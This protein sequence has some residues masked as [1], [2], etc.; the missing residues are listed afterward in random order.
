MK[1][2]II[3]CFIGLTSEIAFG[4]TV[5]ETIKSTDN[6]IIG[7]ARYMG[8]AG[9]F[10]A[11]GGDVSA[12]KDNPAGLGIFR[13]SELTATV[14]ALMQATTA[15]WNTKKTDDS[16]YS[17]GANNVSLVLASKTWRAES[18]YA[19]LI[20]SNFSF[21]YNKLQNFN[22]NM[23]IQSNTVGSSMTDYF[24]HFTGKNSVLDL[25]WNNYP[26]NGMDTPFQNGALP[27]MSV[28][29]NYGYLINPVYN[30]DNTLKEWESLLGLDLYT[31]KTLTPAYT[32]Q[33]RGGIDEYSFGWSG[34]FSNRLYLG[35]TLNLQSIKHD[36][37]SNYSEK[38]TQG[39][40]MS[41]ANNLQ[42]S[43]S[44]VNV[45]L[46]IIAAPVDFM[47]IGLSM[48]TPMFYNMQQLN[49]ATLNFN[50]IL[51]PDNVQVSGNSDTPTDN[52][53]SYRMQTPLQFNVSTAFIIN[54]KGFVSA[55]Y[56][57]KNY[58]G[59]KV[60]D[61]TGNAH[62]YDYDFVNDDI[63]QMLNDARTI[64][65]GAEYRLSDNFSLRAGYANT[66]AITNNKVAKIFDSQTV[67]TDPEYF[68]HNS[69]DYSSLG[70]G[71]RESN[72]YIDFAY[73]NKAIHENY[74][75]YNS[76]D[77]GTNLQ[78]T[79]ATVKTSN[80]NIVITFGLKF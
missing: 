30:S 15:N 58:K 73:I 36:Y 69:T 3:A 18:G 11:L 26:Q 4:Q 70:L 28:M 53:I 33:E 80:N 71:Y 32:L 22:R 77:L 34:N 1:R 38:Y 74:Y 2:F 7:T 78:T 8:V 14:N 45:N 46:G 27:W 68:A 47:R 19:G 61:E 63:K 6:D 43:G 59:M 42:T 21:S 25:D 54:S 65:L 23:M 72:W 79:P 75:A 48:H 49:Y 35:A 66:S 12:I 5:F 13:K 60:M 17:V 52:Y 16:N 39:G 44:G 62:A 64:K 31:D 56:V 24:A 10:G 67:R 51:A 40:S 20:N 76:A 41:L 9:A 29:A 37:S 50:N 55:E 57:Y